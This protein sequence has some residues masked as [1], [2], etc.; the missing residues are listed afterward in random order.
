MN[1]L[2]RRGTSFLFTGTK[3]P[4]ADS[5]TTTAP[6]NTLFTRVD[7][8]IDGEDCDRDCDSCTIRYP[9]KFEID[10]EDKL[11]GNVKGW[12]THVLI[13][14]GK[15]DWVRDVAD[16]K[17]SVME[18]IEKGGLKPSNGTM[19]LSASNIPVPDEYHHHELGKQPTTA[20]I[21]PA[22]TVV[23]HVTPALAADLITYFVNPA[24]TTTSPLYNSNIGELPSTN[25]PTPEPAPG[26]SA[27]TTSPSPLTGTSSSVDYTALTPLRSRPCLHTAVILLCSQRTRDARCGQSAPLLRR[28]F[29]R[30]LRARGLYRDLNDERLGGVGIYFISHV[31]GHKYSANVIVYRRRTKSDFADSTTEPSAVSVEEGAVQGIWLARVRPEDCEGIVKFTVL[32]GKVVKPA[33]QLRG[34]FDREKGLVIEETALLKTLSEGRIKGAALDV[35]DV[36]PLP[37]DSQWRTTRWGVEGRSEVLLSPHLG[38]AEEEIMNRWYEEQAENIERWLDGKEVETRLL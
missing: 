31:G 29:E 24:L 32:Q 1:S 21:L 33:S 37:G 30:H 22:F 7:P 9:S 27:L 19:K 10:T 35:F 13:A 23:E 28:E 15:T 36:E 4:V 12:A 38:Y 11:Y 8:S 18:A 25:T 14:T 6:E 26:T 17:G 34:G 16:E 20:L 5:A 2:L 3:S